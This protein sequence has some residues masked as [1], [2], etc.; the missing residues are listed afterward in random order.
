MLNARKLIYYIIKVNHKCKR[1]SISDILIYSNFSVISKM[2]LFAFGASK[3]RFEKER[4][5]SAIFG[6]LTH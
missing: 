2:Y 6:N 3:R 4:R 1:A 5:P